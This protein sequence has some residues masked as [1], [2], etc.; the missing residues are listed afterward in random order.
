MIS[1]LSLFFQFFHFCSFRASVNFLTA[2]LIVFVLDFVVSEVFFRSR[3]RLFKDSLSERL[4]TN[5]IPPFTA[6]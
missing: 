6:W 1:R 3:V 2:L 4:Q 5:H